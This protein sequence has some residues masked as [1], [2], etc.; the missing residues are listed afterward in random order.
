MQLRPVGVIRGFVV[1]HILTLAW[2][3]QVGEDSYNE[4]DAVETLKTIQESVDGLAQTVRQLEK[5]VTHAEEEAVRSA[6]LTKNAVVGTYRMVEEVK[7]RTKL[8]EFAEEAVPKINVSLNSNDEA[9]KLMVAQ[10]QR[11]STLE[12]RVKANFG[13][14]IT[15]AEEQYLEELIRK[16]WEVADPDEETS[17]ERIQERIDKANIG[18]SDLKGALRHEIRKVVGR[19]LRG[20][21]DGLRR[22]ISSMNEQFGDVIDIHPVNAH[23]AESDPQ[24]LGGLLGLA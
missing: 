9:L 7:N 10:D 4:S 13:D 15:S 11:I 18:F 23:H 8:I 24:E 16:L 14:A 19:R 17:I 20:K 5:Q 12:S 3:V 1:L 21:T 22:D 6:N 2:A